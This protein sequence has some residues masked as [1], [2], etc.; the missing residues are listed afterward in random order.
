MGPGEVSGDIPGSQL[1]LSGKVLRALLVSLGI[2]Y[3]SAAFSVGSFSRPVIQ[4]S[5]VSFEELNV[6]FPALRLK[7]SK[8]D[9]KLS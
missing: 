2:L 5:D 3:G 9:F 4:L 6:F 1:F 7:T 8:Q